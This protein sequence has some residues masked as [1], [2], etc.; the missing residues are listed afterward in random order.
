MSIEND[1]MIVMVLMMGLMQYYFEFS[2]GIICGILKVILL[3]VREDWV[4]LVE[5]L[6]YFVD[7]GD[8]LVQYVKNLVFILEMFVMIWDE[9]NSKE[10]VNFW[11]QIVWIKKKF[12]CGVGLIEYD[13]LGW[14]MGFL[15]WREDGFVRVWDVGNFELLEYMIMVGNVIYVVQVFDEFFIGY[16][17]V[18]FKMLDYLVLGKLI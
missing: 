4:R 2:G 13:V 9:L 1:G 5:K 10:V 11:K 18:F 3:G 12:I 17:K 14:I 15:Y 7:W 16:V 6:G 8:E